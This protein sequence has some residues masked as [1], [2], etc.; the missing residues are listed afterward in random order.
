MTLH[1]VQETADFLP[2]HLSECKEKYRD[3]PELLQNLVTRWYVLDQHYKLIDQSA[4]Y[5]TAILL[6]PSKRKNYLTAAWK[7]T[8]V[9]VSIE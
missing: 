9:Q 1:A 7:Q 2:T 6:H 3:I 4:A 5:V 8:W